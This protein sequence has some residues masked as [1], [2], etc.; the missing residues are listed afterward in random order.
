MLLH[1]T[2]VTFLHFFIRKKERFCSFKKLFYNKLLLN[3]NKSSWTI[4][5]PKKNI[6]CTLND[7]RRSNHH[8]E[9]V[10]SNNGKTYIFAFKLNY[11]YWC[12]L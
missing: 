12:I 10:N 7:Q 6:Y 2:K 4:Q 9:T 3:V 8:V 5:S 1:V 11:S